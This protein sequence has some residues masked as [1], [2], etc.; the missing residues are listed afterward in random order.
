[1]TTT[2]QKNLKELDL[3]VR[4]LYSKLHE[5]KNSNS[6]YIRSKNDI[7]VRT[8][9]KLN[10]CITQSCDKGLWMHDFLSVIE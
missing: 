9:S 1:M 5:I 3:E 10:L 7:S 8:E 2:E 4:L 6:K